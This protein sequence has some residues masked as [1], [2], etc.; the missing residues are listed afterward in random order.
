LGIAGFAL[1]FSKVDHINIVP[2]VG[3]SQSTIPQFIFNSQGQIV[4]VSNLNIVVNPNATC[5]FTSVKNYG[6]TGNG[7][8]DDT[9]SIQNAINNEIGVCFPA[10]RYLITRTLNITRKKGFVLQGSGFA[11]AGEGQTRIVWGGPANGTMVVVMSSDSVDISYVSLEGFNVNQPPGIGLFV[12]ALNAMGGTHWVKIHDMAINNITGNP[13]VGLKVGSET[14]DDIG[15]NNFYRLLLVYNKVDLL[16]VGIQTAANYYERI[17]SLLFENIGIWHVAGTM[18]ID[19]SNLFG[20]ATATDDI[21]VEPTALEFTT[22]GNYHELL[23]N[24]TTA[25]AYHFVAGTRFW[26]TTIVNARMLTVF[27]MESHQEPFIFVI[28]LLQHHQGH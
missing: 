3:G 7:V 22:R 20:S 8:T 17:V 28:R 23:Y 6:A 9:T 26:S 4:S 21:R 16:Q 10:G 5:A 14:D 24:R 15:N 13:G 19:N 11:S 27:L 12:T 18:T 1:S 25:R 2:G